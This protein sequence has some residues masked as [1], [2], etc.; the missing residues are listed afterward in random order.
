MKNIVLVDTS[1]TSFYRFFATLKWISLVDAEL[2][3]EHKDDNLYNWIENEKF[4]DK[5][6]KMYLNSI[7]KIIKKKTFNNSH[8]IFCMDTPVEQ[9]WRTEYKNDYKEGRCDLTRKANFKP[10][11]TY[12]YDVIIPKIIKENSNINKI[13]IAKLEADDV[14][15]CITRYYEKTDPKQKIII[16]TGDDDFLQLGRDNV[17]FYNYKS[18]QPKILTKIEAKRA[19]YKKIIFGDPSDCIPSIFKPKTRKTFKEEM[20]ASKDKLKDYLDKDENAMKQYKHNKLMIDFRNI[21]DKLYN[22]VINEYKKLQ[23]K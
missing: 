1:Y 18:K 12:T 10:A 17:E 16:I 15:A 6:E 22:Q 19:L 8:I 7:I 2:Y 23:N 21:P 5:Y 3:K 13:R 9:V 4:K 11:F 14:C 20:L